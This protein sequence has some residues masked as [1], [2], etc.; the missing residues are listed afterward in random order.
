LYEVDIPHTHG[1]GEEKGSQIQMFVRVPDGASK[2]KP[3]PV[4]MFIDGLDAYRTDHGPR[5][6]EHVSRGFACVSVEIP[7]TG[8]SPAIRNDPKSP[9]RQWSTVLDWVAT[10]EHFDS[11][12]V[13]VRGVSCG[14]YYAM[15]IAH[16]HADRLFAVVAQGG[17]SHHMFDE[18]WIRAQ[19]NMEYP[20]A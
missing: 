15:R 6:T 20:Y 17:G 18:R 1:I 7:G 3:V 11:S 10:Q 9:E 16:T 4:L 14:G 8:D 13:V 2:A 12:K 5:V 19:N